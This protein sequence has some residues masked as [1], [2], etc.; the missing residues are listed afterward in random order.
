LKLAANRLGG[1]YFYFY[2][3]DPELGSKLAGLETTS[4]LT[5]SW[6]YQTLETWINDAKDIMEQVR[7]VDK[8]ENQ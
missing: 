8:G 2:S 7:K 3:D 4:V 5:Y 1:K 6:S